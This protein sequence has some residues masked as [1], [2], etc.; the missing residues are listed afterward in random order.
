M[1]ITIHTSHHLCLVLSY[2]KKGF[3]TETSPFGVCYYCSI[4]LEIPRDGKKR[5]VKYEIAVVWFENDG[6]TEIV[7]EDVFEI[8]NEDD[9]KKN[10]KK[11]G[12]GVI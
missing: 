8:E 7:R 9:R 11:S 1:K 10:K 6:V 12:V 3:L 4:L 2:K 5:V